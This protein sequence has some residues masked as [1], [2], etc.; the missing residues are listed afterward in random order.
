[1]V[2]PDSPPWRFKHWILRKLLRFIVPLAFHVSIRNRHDMPSQEPFI[3]VS[4]HRYD[5][6]SFVLSYAIPKPIIWVAA[7]FLVRLPLVKWVVRCF[8]MITVRRR[9]VGN[10]AGMARMRNHL[11]RGA[12]IGIFPEG[13]DYLIRAD[14]TRPM[15]AFYRGFCNISVISGVPVYPVA[16]IPLRER[17]YKYPIPRSLRKFFGVT[18]DLQDVSFRNTYISLV[19]AFGKPVFPRTDL[20]RD[21]ASKDVHDRV[22]AELERLQSQGRPNLNAG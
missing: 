8:D 15:T 10:A 18:P 1:V 14:F 17:V 9:G 4:N 3:L 6:D 12:N 19:L 20:P 21:E 7:D 16:I 13:M 2:R 11:E 5:L 22:R